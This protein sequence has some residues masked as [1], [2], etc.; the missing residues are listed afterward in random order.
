MRRPIIYRNFSKIFVL[1]RIMK[2]IKARI[3]AKKDFFHK[4]NV[5]KKLINLIRKRLFL[6]GSNFNDRL[7]T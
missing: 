5:C 7:K 6:N 4:I 3:S 2:C 1:R